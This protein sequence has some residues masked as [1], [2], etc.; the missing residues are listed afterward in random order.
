LEG[1][2]ERDYDRLHKERKLLIEKKQKENEI[3][4]S[5]KK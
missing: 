1:V 5:L 4:T 3:F 2:R